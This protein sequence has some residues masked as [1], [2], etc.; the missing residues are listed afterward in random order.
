MGANI[1]KAGVLDTIQDQGR[2]GY[3]SW[4][5]NP[6]G[7][8]DRYASQ[9]SNILIGNESH[10]A[11]VE[12]HFPGPQ[13]LF[14]QNALISVSG[15][16]FTPLLNDQPIPLWQPVVVRRNTILQFS[17]WKQGARCYLAVHGGLEVNKWLNS[18]S[19]NIKAGVGGFK[20]RR[21]EKGDELKF[22]DSKIYFSAFLKEGKDLQP[23]GWQADVK[24]MYDQP[25]EIFFV[26]GHEWNEL[27]DRSKNVLQL[28][29]FAIHSLSDRMGYHLTG[30]SLSMIERKELLTSG[31]SFGTIQLLPN[32]Q[33]IVLMADH[34]T[35][36]GYPRIGHIISAHLPK[37]AQ[38]RAG[39]EIRF[40][41]TDI[42]TAEQLHFDQGRD[43]C[44][45]TRACNCN[46]NKMTCRL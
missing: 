22:G 32:G 14:E 13:I 17:Q 41:M 35:T 3:G 16:D 44:I 20:G 45:L 8:M 7:A 23:L 15:A 42:N 26:P 12:I 36:G 34:Q 11:V 24:R 40:T 21:L 10:Q 31:V 33:L 18:Y 29:N 46:L 6:G 27:D 9:I 43:I 28:E 5:I 19:T 2:H 30:S 37:L 25:N 39:D 38:H 4:G 1:I